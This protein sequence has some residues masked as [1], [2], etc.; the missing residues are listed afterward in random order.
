MTQGLKCHSTEGVEVDLFP[1]KIQEG[2]EQMLLG[3]NKHQT[4]WTG[5]G[6][7]WFNFSPVEGLRKD[8]ICLVKPLKACRCLELKSYHISI[9]AEI[10]KV[11]MTT[12]YN[13]LELQQHWCAVVE[14]LRA[15]YSHDCP[16]G[17]EAVEIDFQLGDLGVLQ[18]APDAKDADHS[19]GCGTKVGCPNCTMTLHVSG[20]GQTEKR[21]DNLYHHSPLSYLAL[22]K[23]LCDFCESMKTIVV[24]I[25]PAT[26]F[27]RPIVAYFG[28]PVLSLRQINISIYYFFIL[29]GISLI[30]KMIE[31]PLTLDFRQGNHCETIQAYLNK[32]LDF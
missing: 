12:A 23:A 25:L 20:E 31:F 17:M 24:N 28:I 13:G 19:N 4:M 1:K 18:A 8:I 2:N 27:L 16:A 5:A 3:V 6:P 32:M 9:A 21:R 26:H 7:Q 11:P 14:L 22:N 15:A 10:S 29:D 30:N